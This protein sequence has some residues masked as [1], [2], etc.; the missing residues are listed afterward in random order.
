M[1]L[2]TDLDDVGGTKIR[3]LCRFVLSTLLEVRNNCKNLV[4]RI[5]EHSAKVSIL[6]RS[7]KMD[8][9]FSSECMLD[10]VKINKYTNN[11]RG[12]YSNL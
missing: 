7:K 5:G 3:I 4:I 6:I 8:C 12:D 9:L 11:N 10:S 2:P 1:D